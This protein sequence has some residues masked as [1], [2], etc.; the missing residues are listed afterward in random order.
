ME[1][2]DNRKRDD[3]Y[4]SKHVDKLRSSQWCK[5]KDGS[6][7]KVRSNEECKLGDGKT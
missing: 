1:S 6:S 4:K 7:Y 2:E 3:K 5:L